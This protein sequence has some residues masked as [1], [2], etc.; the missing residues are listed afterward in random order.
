MG[1]I[2]LHVKLIILV[3]HIITLSLLQLKLP[4][5][6]IVDFRK[7]LSDALL[8]HT[9][10]YGS[11]TEKLERTKWLGYVFR[12]HQHIILTVKLAI[13]VNKALIKVDVPV[14][15]HVEFLANGLVWVLEDLP[16]QPYWQRYVNRHIFCVSERTP[17]FLQSQI[18]NRR[19]CLLLVD[20][21]DFGYVLDADFSV[22]ICVLVWLLEGVL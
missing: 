7:D 9:M 6:L 3:C 20:E 8:R 17:L 13:L 19:H 16:D 10:F 4:L 12:H 22:S 1:Q 5:V 14:F 21:V 2:S 18:L 15:L 11:A